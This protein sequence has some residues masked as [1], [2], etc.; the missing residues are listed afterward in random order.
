MAIIA[1]IG[2]SVLFYM[3]GF[4]IHGSIAMGVLVAFTTFF[5]GAIAV[6]VMGETSVEP[7]SGTSFIVLLMLFAVFKLLQIETE[8]A[9]IMALLGTTVFG[10]AISMSGDIIAD[11]KNALYIGNR[12]YLQMKGETMGIIPGMVVA[13][14]SA[15]LFSVG[16]ATG[17]LNLV[18]PQGHAFEGFAKVLMGGNVNMWLLLIGAALGVGMDLLTGMGTSFG[19]G[20]YFPL[21]TSLPMLVGGIA[22]D[23]WEKK[24]LEPKAKRE[25]W[26]ERRKTTTL[27]DTYMIATGMTVGEAIIGTVV[28]IYLVVP[29][30]TGSGA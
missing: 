29:L 30:I 2:I 28:A 6:K 4:P 8:V 19:L 7:V 5:F 26:D 14:F 27:L 9:M 22:R 21:A 12:P 16:L 20:M 18:A 3:G 10:G 1:S 23:L 17:A 25:N 24:W 11:F 15:M 13:G